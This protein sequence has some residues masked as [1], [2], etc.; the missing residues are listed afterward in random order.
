MPPETKTNGFIEANE[1]LKQTELITHA[2]I[3]LCTHMG[4]QRDLTL[5][6]RSSVI[7]KTGSE[8]YF[9]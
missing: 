8:D 2:R 3:I 6:G 5:T 7:G 4:N 9:P 1:S